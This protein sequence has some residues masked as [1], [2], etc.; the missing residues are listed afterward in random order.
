MPKA[1]WYATIHNARMYI[2][3]R[4]PRRRCSGACSVIWRKG[5]STTRLLG[6]PWKPW[7]THA[8]LDVTWRDCANCCRSTTIARS[9]DERDRRHRLDTVTF[10]LARRAYR[11]NLCGSACAVPQA[12]NALPAGY[13]RTSDM[14]APSRCHTVLV[15]AFAAAAG[16][17][18]AP[19][20]SARRQHAIRDEHRCLA[21]HR[22]RPA[23]DG[24]L[25]VRG[26]RAARRAFGAGVVVATA[27]APK[28]DP[29]E[30]L[31]RT[32]RSAGGAFRSAALDLAAGHSC[33]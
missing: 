25:V 33:G 26:C 22:C 23:L 28:R 31:E 7:A 10:P 16:N 9:R 1:W 20:R 30:R 14:C 18:P 19:A 17:L 21:S 5:S 2:A 11:R 6:W 27:R 3:R 12:G 24:R 13:R 32:H 4:W 29:G 8:F 15:M